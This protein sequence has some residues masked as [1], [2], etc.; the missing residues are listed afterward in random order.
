MGFIEKTRL[1]P[2]RTGKAAFAVSEKFPF[3]KAFCDRTAVNGHKGFLF[4]T[5]QF[6]YGP[7]DQFLA[8]A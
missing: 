1:L 3:K 7:G 4:A 5:T 2:V 8:G 6:V